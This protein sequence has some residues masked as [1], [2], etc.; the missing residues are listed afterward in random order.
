MH[1]GKVKGKANGCHR[2]RS[3][4]YDKPAL[5]S[6]YFLLN[7]PGIIQRLFIE[8]FCF[9]LQ[10]KE[11][12][13]D[14]KTVFVTINNVCTVNKSCIGQLSGEKGQSHYCVLVNSHMQH[15]RTEWGQWLCCAVLYMFRYWEH[16]IAQFQPTAEQIPQSKIQSIFKPNIFAWKRKLVS[17]T[18]LLYFAILFKKPSECW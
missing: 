18:Q 10:V 17:V 1:F 16:K 15:R 5:T 11:N 7:F 14:V 8:L 9:K 4:H 6:K 2:D 12:L 13:F 3:Y